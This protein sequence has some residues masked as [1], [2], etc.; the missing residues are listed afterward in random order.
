MKRLILAFAATMLLCSATV[1]DYEIN[2]NKRFQQHEGWGVSLCWWANMCG[3]QDE[4]HLDSLITW[5]VS[6]E[7]LNYNIFR[8]NI[9]GGDDPQNRYCSEHHMGRGKGLRAEMEGFQDERGGEYHWDRDQAQIRVMRMIKEKRPDAIFEAFSN[10]APYWMTN[11]GCVGGALNP[12]DDNLNPDYY[13]DFAHYLVDVC[14]HIKDTYGIEFRTLDPFNEPNTD[15]WNCSG[16]QEGCHFDTKS[17]IDFIR[18][19]YPILQESGLSTVISACDETNVGKSIIA[20]KD[21]AD[22]GV[23]SMLGQ[24]NTHT[25]NGTAE[26]KNELRRLT[27][28]QGIRLW[29]SE[30]GSGG[31]GIDGNLRMAKRLVEDIRC[32]QPAAWVDW[33]YVEQRGDQWSLVT[34]HDWKTY[35]RNRNYYV[36]QHFSRFIPAGYTFV[37]TTCPDALAAISP[38]GNRLVFV[39]VNNSKAASRLSLRVPDNYTLREKYLTTDETALSSAF[40]ANFSSQNLATTLPRQSI[41]TFVFVR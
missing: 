38:D 23:L 22:A 5:L 41:A 39:V 20:F 8:Y 10:S 32:L 14:R 40:T 13:A 16:S 15:Y 30:T 29:Q 6:P 25:Y 34:S 11:S 33:Q 28:E 7:G 18:V 19:L 35:N 17:Q 26:E 31:R 9:G 12:N 2:T 3:Q 1:A 27:T 24:F 36:R 37:D 4:A 21:Y